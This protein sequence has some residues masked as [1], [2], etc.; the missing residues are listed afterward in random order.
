MA[1]TE[2]DVLTLADLPAG[3]LQVLL[4]PWGLVVTP[5][6]AGAAIPGSYW[7]EREAGLIGRC[8]YV[9]ADTP[10]H[11]ALHEAGHFICMDAARRELVEETG[12]S[13]GRVEV[14][15]TGPTS[16]CA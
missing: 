9:R 13:P 4:D 14:L 16:G 12:W 3:A 2:D 7:G 1:M 15:L 6:A 8:L 10:V 5:V 11:S